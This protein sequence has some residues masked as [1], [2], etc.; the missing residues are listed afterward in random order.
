MQNIFY[1]EAPYHVLYYDNELHAYRTDKF[2]NWTNQP[3]DNGTPL[4]GYGSGRLHRPE[5]R[6][7][8]PSRIALAVGGAVR[9]SGRVCRPVGVTPRR[10]RVRAVAARPAAR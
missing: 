6:V 10:P 8:T 2:T 9:R 4:F 5:G 1:D 7:A 3:P